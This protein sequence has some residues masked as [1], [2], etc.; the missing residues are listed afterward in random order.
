MRKYSEK[1]FYF[2]VLFIF[3]MLKGQNHVIL[4]A[5]FIHCQKGVLNCEKCQEVFQYQYMLLDVG[6]DSV[7]A[8]PV[9][10]HEGNLKPYRILK[11]FNSLE[12]AKLYADNHKIEIQ[13][14][15]VDSDE[16][17]RK[18]Q[19]K[20]KEL[21]WHITCNKKELRIFSVYPV[22]ELETGKYV[23]PEIVFSLRPFNSKLNY[24]L[25]YTDKFKVIDKTYNG[26][27]SKMNPIQDNPKEDAL[28]KL[29][30]LDNFLLQFQSK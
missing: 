30:E 21:G 12:N 11:I 24:A 17:I 20:V 18:I 6:V 23:L 8:S 28:Q 14:S 26:F 25:F 19:T 1:I 4:R 22:K 13:I 27:H 10:E 5:P 16:V 7:Y 29:R 15:D 9:I 3:N 2:F